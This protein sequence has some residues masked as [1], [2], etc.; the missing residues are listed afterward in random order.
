MK[1]R[2]PQN[3]FLLPV[4]ASSSASA[5]PA[6]LSIVFVGLMVAAIAAALSSSVIADHSAKG[7]RSNSYQESKRPPSTQTSNIKSRAITGVTKKANP[8]PARIT[9]PEDFIRRYYPRAKREWNQ[10][11]S[12]SDGFVQAFTITRPSGGKVIAEFIFQ[13][14]PGDEDRCRGEQRGWFTFTEIPYETFEEVPVRRVKSA[15]E[16]TIF[17]VV[18]PRTRSTSST[19][20]RTDLWPKILVQAALGIVSE[21]QSY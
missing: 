13:V 6:R 21:G 18:P 7:H 20:P 5:N 8:K 9:S 4:P 11:F 1:V 16:M 2:G 14:K 19:K 10:E 17:T 12:G 15:A 3:R